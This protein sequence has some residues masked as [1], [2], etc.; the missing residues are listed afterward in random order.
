MLLASVQ[1]LQ[2]EIANLDLSEKGPP[3]KVPEGGPSD[4]PKGNACGAEARAPQDGIPNFTDFW[5]STRRQ[6]GF[7]LCFYLVKTHA[8][9]SL[10]RVASDS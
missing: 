10:G 2:L 6:V 4:S 1:K 7:A 3:T 9:L 5:P 8:S